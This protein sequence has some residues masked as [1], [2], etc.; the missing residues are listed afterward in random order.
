MAAAGPLPHLGGAGLGFGGYVAR[1]PRGGDPGEPVGRS[2][3]RSPGSTIRLGSTTERMTVASTSSETATPEA[4]LL[5]HDRVAAWVAGE[6][7]DG[8]QRCSGNDPC[9]G[10]DAPAEGG[11]GGI[12]ASV[13]A[14]ADAAEQEYLVVHGSPNRTKTGTAAPPGIDHVHG[15]EAEHVGCDAV[16]EDQGRAGRTRHRPTAA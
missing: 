16:L 1:P 11:G 10:G 13:V 9:G 4:H 6:D 7:Y 12:G 15:L 8:D 3:F 14:L 2:H 5:E